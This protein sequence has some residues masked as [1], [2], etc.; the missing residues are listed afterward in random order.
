MSTTTP[1]LPALLRD[2]RIL[3]VEDNPDHQP[4]LSRMLHN[5]GA[6]VTLADNGR[7]A[8]ALVCAA[9][10]DG[11][12]FD[13]ILMDIQMPVLDGY[14]AKE[15]IRDLGVTTP[16]VAISGC[17]IATERDKCL[18]AGFD[19]FLGKPFLSGELVTRI[20]TQLQKQA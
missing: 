7:S 14:A 13:V 18:A 11:R 9:D 2:R 20:T 4:L 6:Q 8:V 15:G 5:A 1:T 16:I 3:L 10:Q 12:P 19:D 17:A